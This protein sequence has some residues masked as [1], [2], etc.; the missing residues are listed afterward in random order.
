MVDASNTP[1]HP[2][3]KPTTW[4]PWTCSALRTTARITALSPG[5]SPPP[6]ST[7]TFMRPSTSSAVATLATRRLPAAVLL[8][9]TLLLGT[10]P[11]AS[12]ADPPPSVLRAQRWA[13]VARIASTPDA[14]TKAEAVA[15]EARQRRFVSNLALDDARRHVARY[16]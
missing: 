1:F 4:S 6:V 14:V 7:P 5:Q 2:S 3:R 15:D 9:A 11:S 8:A 12:P 10:M 13:L 16:V